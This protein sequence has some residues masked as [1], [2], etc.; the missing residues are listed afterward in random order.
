MIGET[1][2][3]YRLKEELGKGEIGVIYKAE[4]TRLGRFAAVRLLPIEEASDPLVAERFQRE[5]CAASALNHANIRTIYGC[6]EDKG[7][8][9]IAMELLDGE[10]LRR[11]IA[12]RPFEPAALLAI[13]IQL[14]SALETAHEQGIIHRNIKS[15]N[16][17][18]ARLPT[19]E[20]IPKIMEF[21]LSKWTQPSTSPRPNAVGAGGKSGSTV[22]SLFLRPAFSEE[23]LAYMSPEQ[24]RVAKLD[25]RTDIFSLGVVLYEMAS[26]RLPF[27]GTNRQELFEAI[28]TQPPEPLP[29]L[30]AELWRVI[31][32]C[33]QKDRELRYQDAGQLLADLKQ[34]RQ[35]L[36][37]APLR[38]QNLVGRRR[39]LVAIGAIALI[40]LLAIGAWSLVSRA[41]KPNWKNSEFTQLTYHPAEDWFP[42]LSPDGKSFAYASR[43]A[44]RWDVYV[45]PVGGKSPLNLTAAVP[46]D[47]PSTSPSFSPDGTQIAFRSGYHG[48]GIFVIGIHGDSMRR[49]A[50]SGYNPSW[51]PDG[52]YLVVATEGVERPEMRPGYGQLWRITVSTG[53][54]QRIYAGDAVQPAWS[55]HGTR[56]AYWHQVEGQR[57]LATIPSAGGEPVPITN[58]P[59]TDW[60]PAWSPDG[61][62]LYFASDRGGSMNLWRVR[63]DERSG[64]V[65]GE[66]EPVA[67]PSEDSSHLSFS[68][69]GRHLAFVRRTVTQN[70]QKAPFD[71]VA[72]RVTGAP[73]AVTRGSRQVLNPDIS[74]DGESIAFVHWGNHEDLFVMRMDGT[75]TR[76]LT[77]DVYKD[78]GPRWSPDGKHIAFYSNRGGSYQVWMINP[79]GS[80][81]KQ[82]TNVPGGI[83]YPVWSPDG[84]RIVYSAQ[85][86][87]PAILDLESGRAEELPALK[88]PV[89]WHEIWSWSPDGKM[90][91]GVE[92][93]PDGTY[94][95]I[96]TYALATATLRK[97]TDHGTYPA[98]M[99]DNRTLI[100][101]HAD[102]LYAL[103]TETRAVREAFAPDRQIV[104]RLFA[105]SPDNRTLLFGLVEGDSD[106]WMASIK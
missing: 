26:G 85:R 47:Q 38:R 12:T 103:D 10:T 61:Q 18:L 48:G 96:I 40:A 24:T 69:D 71:S 4:D 6:G 65:L 29:E 81:L 5:A 87:Q 89:G 9:F 49:V 72:A 77:D 13:A 67:T 59:Y 68:R 16:I 43:A 8:R 73:V 76:Q 44:G 56:I 2:S 60:S 28:A 21:G 50:D 25:G 45:Q 30:P 19:G 35:K 80:G 15:S 42:S 58:D 55:P 14:A 51:S 3:H 66:L 83:L 93:M 98:W 22:V 90:L 106:I 34:V 79:D 64:K 104:S 105:L 53:E 20:I 101:P 57:D 74:P 52:R 88:H 27:R 62:Y 33:L 17:F 86:G 97:L 94:T 70:F 75:G 84:K 41:D 31:L 37:P 99:K 82:V 7:C 1:I 102:R 78:R 23:A 32:R 54:K 63:L 46:G 92:R 11:R 39:P 95:G 91:A 100:F 36:E